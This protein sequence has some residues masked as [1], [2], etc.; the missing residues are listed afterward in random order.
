MWSV[1][2]RTAR[3]PAKWA[4]CCGEEK[5]P[6]FPPRLAPEA[7]TPGLLLIVSDAR[8]A[9][10]LSF[11]I[12]AQDLSRQLETW[13]TEIPTVR[14]RD[15]LVGSSRLL[16]I[17]V[18]EGFRSLLRIYDFI[19]ETGRS[20]RVR[21]FEIQPSSGSPDVLLHDVTLPVAFR[22][23]INGS[24]A[25][26]YAEMS[27]DTLVAGSALLRVDVEAPFAYWA[28]TSTTHNETQHFTITTPQPR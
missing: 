9:D 7:A 26:G 14:E 2:L 19:P 25:P 5:P 13:G 28:F 10:D 6:T 4:W 18:G 22:A 8:T 27:L 17:R 11:R 15:A 21:V 16:D 1:R 12:R 23:D 24:W 3:S 20:V